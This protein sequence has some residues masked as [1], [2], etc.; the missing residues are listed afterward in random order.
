MHAPQDL[1]ICFPDYLPM[2]PLVV[3]LDFL[4]FPRDTLCSGGTGSPRIT[5]KELDPAAKSLAVMAFNPFIKTCCSFSPWLIWNLP[6]GPVIPSGIPNDPVVEIP[7]RALQGRNDFGTIGYT[8]PC[9]GPG[10][11]QRYAFKVYSL[12]AMISLSPGAG[13]HELIAALRGH[14]LQYGETAAVATG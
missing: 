11:M 7:V 9:P 6:P 5:L 8:G 14:V 3:T 2:K 12:D 10:E 1:Y 13:K 4:E